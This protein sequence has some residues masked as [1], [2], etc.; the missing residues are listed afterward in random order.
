MLDLRTHPCIGLDRE[1]SQEF[2]DVEKQKKKNSKARSSIMVGD[3][4]LTTEW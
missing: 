3:N 2:V 4:S 1:S